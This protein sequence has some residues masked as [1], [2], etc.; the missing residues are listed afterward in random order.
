MIEDKI[1][2]MVWKADSPNPGLIEHILFKEENLPDH[3]R[4]EVLGPHREYISPEVGSKFYKMYISTPGKDEDSDWWAERLKIDSST[5]FYDWELGDIT[6]TMLPDRNWDDVRMARNQM[7]LSSDNMFNEDT[8]NP[9]KSEWVEY[10]ALLRNMIDREKAAGRTAETVKWDDYIPPYPPSARAGVPD[11]IKIT[12]AWYKG[13]DTYP[14][15]AI[16]GNPLGLNY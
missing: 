12:C 16:I 13:E 3:N 4:E 9:L 15:E 6:Y 14:P 2:L 1:F 7:L 10:R 8:S 5:V 11:D